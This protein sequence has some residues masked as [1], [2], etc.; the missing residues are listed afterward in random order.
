MPYSFMKPQ[1][2]LPNPG[3]LCA[4]MALALILPGCKTLDNLNQNHSKATQ[5]AD[6]KQK[7]KDSLK[8]S[9]QPVSSL[10]ETLAMA[11]RNLLDKCP[12]LYLVDELSELHQFRD[13]SSYDEDEK[14]AWVTLDYASRECAV[15]D[16]RLLAK[17]RLDFNAHLG[18][19][20]RIFEQD[21]PTVSYPYFIAVTDARGEILDKEIHG[22]SLSFES[23]QTDKK[24]REGIVIDVDLDDESARPP[25]FI[26]V[27][28]QLSP[29]E[30]T[31]NQ[32][33]RG[34][35]LAPNAGKKPQFHSYSDGPD[36]PSRKPSQPNRG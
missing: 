5:T 30:L 13:T 22:I 17:I 15:E 32:I 7:D 25:F 16:G 3:V 36:D 21:Q 28:F 20:S 12:E 29:D 18:P 14:I 27:G 9:L 33:I 1:F 2:R 10:D 19:R 4:F 34:K 24:Y 23:D 31:Y 35:L 8:N 26:M 6:F 11:D